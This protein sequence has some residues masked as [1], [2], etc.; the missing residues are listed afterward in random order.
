MGGV[1]GS[2]GGELSGEGCGEHG[3]ESGGSAAGSTV[4]VRGRGEGGHRGK[5]ERVQQ[6]TP[7]VQQQ[8]SDQQG[9]K[10][11]RSIIQVDTGLSSR[12]VRRAAHG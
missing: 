3:G 5:K 8:G 12:A 10:K 1:A 2:A 7:T 9:T 6:G 4:V 11:K